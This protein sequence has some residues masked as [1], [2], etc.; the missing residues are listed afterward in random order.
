MNLPAMY[1]LKILIIIIFTSRSLR[2]NAIASG[3]MLD[4][5]DPFRY[6]DEREEE[7]RFGR[8]VRAYKGVIIFP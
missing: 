2:I 5:H 1:F 4:S 6:R 7:I 3:A 8:D